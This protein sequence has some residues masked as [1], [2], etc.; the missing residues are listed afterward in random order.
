MLTNHH[1]FQALLYQVATGVLSEG[2]IAPPIRDVLRHQ[3]NARVV[4]GEV[5]DIDAE[6]RELTIDT[7][8]KATTLPYDSL[9]VATGA[10]QSYFGHDEYARHAPG[11]KTIDDALELRGRIFGAFE[12]AELEPDDAA[13][14]PWLTFAI[15][16]A[17]PTGVE[18]AGQIAE[19]SRR[20]L[21]ANFRR[22]DPKTARIALI[23]GTDTV[24]PTYSERLRRRA[25]RDLARLGV[26]LRLST[27]VVGIDEAGLDLSSGDGEHA[28]HPG[29]HE[30]LGGRR[31]G[32]AARTSSGRPRRGDRRPHG[33]RRGTARLLTTR[34]PRRVRRRR[35]HGAE[36]PPR[37][38]RGRD[39]E[40]A[41]RR[42]DSR[43]PPA[44][45]EPK[46]FRYVDL[47]TMATV[48]RFRAV[49]SIG[50]VEFGG[51]AGWLLWLGVHLTFLVG[52]RVLQSFPEAFRVGM[53]ARADKLLH[54]GVNDP[55]HWEPAFGSGVIHIGV[56]VFSDSEDTWRRTI[57]AARRHYEGRPGLTVVSAEV[58]G[59]QPGD[60][61]PLGYRDSIG[62]PAVE[63]SGVESLPGQGPAIKA[64]EFI[65]G[66]P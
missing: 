48:S 60:L 57:D 62:Q 35:P 22:F 18:L 58:F 31:A 12:I 9:I 5:V 24:L 51:F 66:Y 61:N 11:M 15:V 59:A 29:S 65:L 13:R 45:R 21:R 64:G 26:E 27:R 16:G 1:L 17:G 32:I 10:S 44:G 20:A 40:R 49:V 43:A 63:G 25:R 6:H 41:P 55:K 36:R 38:G 52:F 7:L 23:D 4:L 42:E 30:D 8:G 14:Q 19:L 39:A 56:S 54:Y 28:P 46:P 34:T 2:D 53:A 47:G 50:G 3:R 37:L 33:S